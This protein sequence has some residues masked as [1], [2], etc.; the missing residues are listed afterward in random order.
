[1]IIVQNLGFS[2]MLD[3]ALFELDCNMTEESSLLERK[4]VVVNVVEDLR[5][6]A[7][8]RIQVDEVLAWRSLVVG[9]QD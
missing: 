4:K 1:M 8:V 7:L 2:S 6:R 3:S 9:W 5:R